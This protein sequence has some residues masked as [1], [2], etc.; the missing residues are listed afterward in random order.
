MQQVQDMLEFNI[1]TPSDEE[2][3][4]RHAAYQKRL[5]QHDKNFQDQLSGARKERQTHATRPVAKTRRV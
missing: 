5:E 2:L 1:E 3:E 4:R